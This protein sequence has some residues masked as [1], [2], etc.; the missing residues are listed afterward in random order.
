MGKTQ[1]LLSNGPK[2]LSVGRCGGTGADT[3]QTLARR[4]ALQAPPG[5]SSLRY[6]LLLFF[7]ILFFSYSCHVLKFFPCLPTLHD[8][9]LP[10]QPFSLYFFSPFFVSCLYLALRSSPAAAAGGH[11]HPPL[12]PTTTCYVRV[13]SSMASASP[14]R[15]I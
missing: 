14:L 5:Y 1:H 11:L 13:N 2:C 9:S 15:T 10:Y 12:D 6:F 4:V 7:F 3:R 8:L